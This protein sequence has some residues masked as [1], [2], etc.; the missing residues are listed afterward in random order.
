MKLQTRFLLSLFFFVTSGCSEREKPRPVVSRDGEVVRYSGPIT[1]E[2]ATNLTPLLKGASRLIIYSQGGDIEAGIF[3][4][5]AIVDNNV[6]VE[7][8]TMCASSCAH[9]VF[10]AAPK[11]IIPSGSVVLFHTSPFTWE[12][13]AKSGYV[14]DNTF[15]K[16]NRERLDS[17]LILYNRAGVSPKLLVCASSLIGVRPETIRPSPLGG[18]RANTLFS[19]VYFSDDM[20]RDF[21]LRDLTQAS[22]LS[23]GGRLAF[24]LEGEHFRVVRPG[25][26]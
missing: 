1:A 21:G 14:K 19:G 9:Y 6:T 10:A 18:V 17:V 22:D 16:E 12:Q 7:V 8:E 3:I 2:G 20:L 25:E 4:G 11:R 15:I 26:C 5:N 24:E 13:L 23:D